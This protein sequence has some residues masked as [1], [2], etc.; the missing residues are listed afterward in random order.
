L[1]SIAP[2]NRHVLSVTQ[3]FLNVHWERKK[4]LLLGYSGG[5][6]SKALLYALIE[7]GVVPHIAHVDHGW[8]VESQEEKEVLEQEA[9][10]LGC[11]FFS[12]RLQLKDKK[13]D[14]ARKGRFSFFSS[15]FA[16]YEALLLAH[17][18]DDLAETVLKRIFE[19]AHLSNLSGMQPVSS[20]YG[21]KIWRPFLSIYRSEILEFLEERQLS[22]FQDPSN[23]DPAYLRAKMRSDLFPFLTERFGKEVTSNLVLLSRRAFE[24][25][26]YLDEKI[27]KICIQRG[28]WGILVQLKGLPIIEQR[29]L[30]Q[31]IAR[32][33]SIVLPR[34]ILET[35]ITWSNEAKESKK[36]IYKTKKIFVEK[37]QVGVFPLCPND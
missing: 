21:M 25:K 11:P 31:K 24:L 34:D 7:C 2:Q 20:Q 6:D 8:R 36:L 15:L 16:Q 12:I 5:P 4:P 35:L 22:P 28:A 23:A 10:Q 9:K 17:Q 13:E 26:K 29:H 3:E 1:Q 27:E 30:L 32:E 19:G 14:E 18:A 37:G 33:E